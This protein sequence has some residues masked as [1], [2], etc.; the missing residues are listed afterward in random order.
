MAEWTRDTK[1]RQGSILPDEACAQFG[2]EAPDGS[3]CI[4]IVASHDCDIAQLPEYEPMVEV[5]CGV[6]V[7]E[8]NGNYTH[9]KNARKLHLALL[10]GANQLCVELQ[11]TKKLTLEKAYLA[12]FTPNTNLKLDIPQLNIFQSWLAA[13]YRRSAFP[14]EFEDRLKSAKLDSKIESLVRPH[15]HAIGAIFFDVDEG[16]DLSKTGDDDTYLLDVVIMYEPEPDYHHN[17]AVAESLRAGIVAAFEKKLFNST[18]K[19]WNKI[20]LRN[21]DIISSD[22][23]S[24]AQ[25]RILKQWRLEFMSLRDQT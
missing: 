6:A 3:R 15:H 5:I 2:I 4:V 21:C 9:T 14:D 19:L 16:Q 1:W 8:I 20:E 18:T 11:A 7:G 25:S 24:Y 13:R 23:L 12:S 22:A 17:L 10:E